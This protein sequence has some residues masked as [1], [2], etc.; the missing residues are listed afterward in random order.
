MCICVIRFIV[1]GLADG[2]F[3]RLFRLIIVG[4]VS[5]DCLTGSF[6]RSFIQVILFEQKGL[7][8]SGAILILRFTLF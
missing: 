2:S 3:T 8:G 1:G 4:I 6:D 5:V 7:H